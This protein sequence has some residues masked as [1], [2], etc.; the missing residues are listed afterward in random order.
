MEI[1]RFKPHKP[2]LSF[3]FFSFC[4]FF[5][6]FFGL[7]A[8]TAPLVEG[9][10]CFTCTRHTQAYVHHLLQTHE[11][12]APVLLLQLVARSSFLVAVFLFYLQSPGR[13]CLL[14]ARLVDPSCTHLST[15]RGD[16]A[17]ECGSL[18]HF[19]FRLFGR[20]LFFPL[21]FSSSFFFLFPFF[22]HNLHHY[23]QFFSD[24]RASITAGRFE[25]DAAEFLAKYELA[26]HS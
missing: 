1:Q 24:I 25:A 21:S 10:R 2:F 19:M 5:F 14:L 7:Q 17:G 23:A 18:L 4:L 16:D 26:V 6:F 11:M 8:A 15:L 22:S 20:C 9:C 13:L 12:L 3:L